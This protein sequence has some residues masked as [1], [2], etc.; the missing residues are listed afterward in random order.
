[1]EFR[2]K[3]VVPFCLLAI[4]EGC[5]VPQARSIQGTSY[6]SFT[7]AG[8]QSVSLPVND[9]GA[10]PAENEFAKILAA[11]FTISPSTG[12]EKQA[13]LAWAFDFEAKPTLSRIEMVRVEEVW[14]SKVP[15]T[16]VEDKS[17]ALNDGVW[18]GNAKPVPANRIETPWLFADDASFYVFRFTIVPTGKPPFVLYQLAWFPASAKQV[19]Q[20]IIGHVEHG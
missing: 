5:S 16:L 11:G 13:A 20:T 7:I 3:L 14:P 4:L 2:W 10:I 18:S 15:V 9:A 1:M 6:V 19:F 8:G 12:N 17:P